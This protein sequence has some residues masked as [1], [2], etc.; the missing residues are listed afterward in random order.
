MRRTASSRR[1]GT[2][3]A[4]QPRPRRCCSG[5]RAARPEILQCLTRALQS[6]P[7]GRRAP[8]IMPA[9]LRIVLLSALAL[10]AA[11]SS[12]AEFTVSPIRLDFEPGRR[13]ATVTVANDDPRPLRLQLKLMEWTQDATGMDVYTESDEL[14]YFPKLVSVQPNDRRLVRVGIKSPAGAAERTYRLF[15]DELPDTAPAAASGLSFSIRFALPIF[16][17]AAQPHASA[18]ID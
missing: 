15:L 12:A 7:I 9:M 11:S 16:L 14:V 13:S 2:A 5:W 4:G 8:H 10:A 17:P 1:S 3:S 6:L 18:V